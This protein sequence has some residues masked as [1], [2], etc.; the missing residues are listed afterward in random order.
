MSTD[1]IALPRTRAG[2]IDFIA[3]VYAWMFLALLIGGGVAAY[4][5]LAETIPLAVTQ[6][7]LLFFGMIV[8]EFVLVTVLTPWVERMPPW[9][10]ALALVGYAAANGITFSTLFLIFTRG[11]TTAA[12]FGSAGMFCVMGVYGYFTRQDL[13]RPGSLLLM[14]LVGLLIATVV[15]PFWTDLL[16][17]WLTTCA[18]VLI[19]VG[20]AAYDAQKIRR[21]GASKA[22]ETVGGE[23]AAVLGA[24]ELYLDLINVLLLLFGVSGR[25]N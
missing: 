23:K 9:L 18:G 15:Y 1:A 11:S 8:G 2:S 6:D 3:R 10:A 16:F 5:L 22:V 21:M 4:N 25:R 12:F 14:A 24:L 17:S 19:F 13:T 20:L 7:P